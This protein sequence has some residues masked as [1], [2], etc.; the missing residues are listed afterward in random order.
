MSIKVHSAFSVFVVATNCN[1]KEMAAS[2]KKILLTHFRNVN[3]E[4]N[5]QLSVFYSVN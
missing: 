4:E 5:D 3:F 2:A 1:K